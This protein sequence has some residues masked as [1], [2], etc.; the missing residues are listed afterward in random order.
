MRLLRFAFSLLLLAASV[1]TAAQAQR[2]PSRREMTVAA[3]LFRAGVEHAREERWEEA[4]DA[5]ARSYETAAVPVTL[6][7]LAGAQAQ[8]GMLLEAAESYRRFLPDAEEGRARA[9]RDHAQSA[10]AELETRIPHVRI[11]VRGE[12]PSDTL[13]LDGATVLPLELIA[14]NPGSH[15]FQVMREGRPLADRTVEF[16]EGQTRTIRLDVIPPVAGDPTEPADIDLALDTAAPGE[17]EPLWKNTWLWVGVAAVVLVG[18]GVAL[19][20]GL[21]T[22]SPDPY[23]GNAGSIVYELQGSR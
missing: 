2:A 12:R 6:Y 4:R 9:H 19:G 10:L 15:R 17:R 18:G 20:V 8:L 22:S 5:F 3:R 13:E 11:E 23:E 1:P 7:N 21:G 14:L 16:T